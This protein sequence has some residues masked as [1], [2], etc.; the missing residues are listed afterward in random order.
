MFAFHIALILLEK[1]WMK[2]FFQQ[3][4][5]NS[6]DH[7]VPAYCLA[8][9]LP[10]VKD[11]DRGSLYVLLNDHIF[12]C[13]ESRYV[14]VF[15]CLNSGSKYHF[16]RF[17]FYTFSTVYKMKTYLVD[18]FVKNHIKNASF[19]MSDPIKYCCILQLCLDE[20][21]RT[22]IY[23]NIR[24]YFY[25][26]RWYLCGAEEQTR[27]VR[28][29]VGSRKNQWTTDFSK[30]SGTYIVYNSCITRSNSSFSLVMVTPTSLFFVFHSSQFMSMCCLFP[31][32]YLL[33]PSYCVFPGSHFC[34]QTYLAPFTEFNHVHR[35][36]WYSDNHFADITFG[37]MKL[38]TATADTTTPA[39]HGD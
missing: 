27:K 32:R 7:L 10:P 26:W 15:H 6:E 34:V 24:S 38:L 31:T 21:R 36:R 9:P 17:D 8:S 1:V 30:N 4:W 29:H 20:Q 11:D 12:T 33:K 16:L 19:N 28:T 35:S 22:R 37:R 13:L 2:L 39:G 14:L 3:L 18:I 5:I 25:F 23:K